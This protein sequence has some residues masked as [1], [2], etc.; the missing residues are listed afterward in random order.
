MLP[1][2][3]SGFGALTNEQQFEHRRRIAARCEAILGQFWRDDDAAAIRALQVEGYVDVLQHV[4]HVELRDA[5]AEY[6]RTGPRSRAGRLLRPDAG[7]LLELVVRDRTR[8]QPP[9]IDR[10]PAPEPMARAGLADRKSAAEIMDEVGFRPRF[11]GWADDADAGLLNRITAEIEAGAAP[12]AIEE[13]WA[14]DIA[15][16]ERRWPD[17]GAKIRAA[18]AAARAR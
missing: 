8:K 4:S 18:L 17:E 7:A 12:A 11:F 16:V 2:L 14:K 6:Q 3:Q 9:V 13:V 15:S 5:W 10:R 1:A